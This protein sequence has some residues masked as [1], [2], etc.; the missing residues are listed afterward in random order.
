ML[1]VHQL[2]RNQ[3]NKCN[4]TRSSSGP[5]KS[6]QSEDLQL[7][8]QCPSHRSNVSQP[9]GVQSTFPR[10]LSRA[11]DSGQSTAHPLQLDLRNLSCWVHEEFPLYPIGGLAS[12]ILFCP[13]VVEVVIARVRGILDQDLKALLNLENL[14]RL[15]LICVKFSF[16]GGLLPM[17]RKFGPKSLE[18]LTL[19][20][21]NEVD[22]AA[23]AQHCSKLRH[24][25]LDCIKQYIQSTP[26]QSKFLHQLNSLEYLDFRHH[27]YLATGAPTSIDVSILLSSPSLL[28]IIIWNVDAL[29]DQEIERAALLNFLPKLNHLHLVTCPNVTSRSIEVLLSLNSPIT[30]LF[31][32]RCAQLSL[33]D[34]NKWKKMV[35]ENNFDLTITSYH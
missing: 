3:G 30:K 11:E 5:G 18:Q 23:I 29:T 9:H 8:V 34:A 32:S 16:D 1:Q 33:A 31:F 17:L 14:E 12:T 20:S 15:F 10:F 19:W 26:E 2:P 27:S 4:G 28:S 35:E 21:V 13:F 6:S 7:R 24:L 22:V 25:S